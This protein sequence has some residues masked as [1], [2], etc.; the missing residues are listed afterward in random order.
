MHAVLSG[1]HHVRPAS[2][3]DWFSMCNRGPAPLPRGMPACS[4]QARVG[5]L[6]VSQSVS[7][8][9]PSLSL[10][11]CGAGSCALVHP[12]PPVLQAG[13]FCLNAPGV[14]CRTHSSRSQQLSNA[15]NQNCG[16]Q[17]QHFEVRTAPSREAAPGVSQGLEWLA[18]PVSQPRFL[19]GG[20]ERDGW[21]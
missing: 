6:S 19:L 17:T 21:F 14:W 12:C 4:P 5:P 9:V 10:P 13:I 2:S 20:L 1:G 15:L 7:P 16:K 8:S 3:S 11:S 18:A